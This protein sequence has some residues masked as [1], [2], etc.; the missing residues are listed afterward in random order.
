MALLLGATRGQALLAARQRERSPS[1]RGGVLALPAPALIVLALM[2][3][4]AIMFL[5][6]RE[7]FPDSAHIELPWRSNSNPWTQAFLWVRANTPRD[8]LFALDVRY[9]NEH[10][11]DA[12]T[13][14][15]T[16]L[17]S[18]LPDFSKDGGEAAITPSLAA[19][20]QQGAAAQANLS[21]EPDAIR[22]AR[23]GPLG[24]TWMVLHS[25]AV[26]RHPCPYDNGTVK[27]CRLLP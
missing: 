1:A 20:W 13:F 19:A 9:I 26:T 7:I 14:R 6:Q 17:R 27:V 11:E 24:V 12:Q 25:S 3:L 15:A 23:L 21:D 16:A 18:A 8:A 2:V 4:A 10:G 22:D 5:V